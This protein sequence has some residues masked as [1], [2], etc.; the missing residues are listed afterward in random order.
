MIFEILSY[1]TGGLEVLI[2]LFI[3]LFPGRKAT[4]FLKL[5]ADV[6]TAINGVFIYFATGNL[7]IFSTVAACTIGAFRD[8]VFGLRDKYKVFNHYYWAIIFAAINLSFLFITYQ[9][10]LSLLPAI[11]AAIS[12]LTLYMY[13]QRITKIGA[14]LCF[15]EYVI[16][17]AILLESSNVLTIF[18]LI[19]ASTTL[20]GSIIGLIYLVFF[21][22]EDEKGN[23]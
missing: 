5:A 20:L 14:I 4:L 15:G 2:G 10:P 17:Y 8:I 23:I 16:F 11:G 19:S 9:S 3:F 12:C 22:K 7:L 6:T 18:S 21:K 1:V 13:D